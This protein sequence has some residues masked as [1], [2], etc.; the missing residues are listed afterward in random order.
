DAAA[1]EG[2]EDRCRAART[3]PRHAR[4]RRLAG[5]GGTSRREAVVA[6]APGGGTRRPGLR[7]PGADGRDG[8]GSGA[9]SVHYRHLT[10][11][12]AGASLLGATP[13]AAVF[14]TY[15]W[16]IYALGVVLVVLGATLAMR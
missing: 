13:L 9:M 10:I 3:Q 8:I 2:P 12:A 11:A 16:F 6:V 5:G 15:T 4:P 7:V 14:R 1:G